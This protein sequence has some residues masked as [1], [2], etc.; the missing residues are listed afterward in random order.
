MKLWEFEYL[1]KYFTCKDEYENC[2]QMT[3]KKHIFQFTDGYNKSSKCIYCNKSI[4]EI[5]IDTSPEDLISPKPSCDYYSWCDKS[6][7][8]KK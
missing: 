3:V 8:Y 1:K 2:A 6:P 4:E 7:S 5:Q